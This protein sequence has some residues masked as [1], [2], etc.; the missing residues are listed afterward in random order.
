M[1]CLNPIDKF[2]IVDLEILVSNELY[3]HIMTCT[4]LFGN[5]WLD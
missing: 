4:T 1:Y 2:Q 3:N 5:K